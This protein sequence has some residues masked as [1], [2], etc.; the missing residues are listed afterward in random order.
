MLGT[1]PVPLPATGPS[2]ALVTEP[3]GY[4]GQGYLSGLLG[5]GG[6]ANYTV[7][8]LTALPPGLVMA[9][10]SEI[11]GMPSAPGVFHVV[12]RVTDAVGRSAT[13]TICLQ[14]ASP[15]TIATTVLPPATVG[16]PYAAPIE[17]HGGYLPIVVQ[18]VGPKQTAESLYASGGALVGTPVS[19]DIASIPM[20]VTDGIATSLVGWPTLTVGPLPARGRCMSQAT[21]PRSARPSRRQGRGTPLL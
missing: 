4:V 8:P 9:S 5:T 13:S 14:F 2:L 19:P 3:Q 1:L 10:D 16:Q 6:T 18:T 7:T 20:I 11:G 21:P 17:V 15:L 12:V